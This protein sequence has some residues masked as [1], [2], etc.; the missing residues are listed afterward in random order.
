MYQNKQ[1]NIIQNY[2]AL[3]IALQIEHLRT[4]ILSSVLSQGCNVFLGS[5]TDLYNEQ[6]RLRQ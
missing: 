5:T 3:M 6:T 4:S 2:I 1:S